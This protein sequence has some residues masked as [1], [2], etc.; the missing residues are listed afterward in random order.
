MKNFHQP[1][2]RWAKK[3]WKNNIKVLQNIGLRVSLVLT[4]DSPDM[5]LFWWIHSKQP[6]KQNIKKK[7]FT[8]EIY[9]WNK[10]PIQPIYLYH[11]ESTCVLINPRVVSILY[12]NDEKS[13]KKVQGLEVFCLIILIICHILII[14]PCCYRS[15][16]TLTLLYIT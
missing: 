13:S 10:H 1:Q 7:N 14:F 11:N 2:M 16:L 9:I 6:K 5:H 8:P 4:N 3:G 12:I 15:F